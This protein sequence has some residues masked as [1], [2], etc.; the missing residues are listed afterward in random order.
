MSIHNRTIEWQHAIMM[1][2]LG[3][4]LL[5]PM[6]SMTSAAF[7]PMVAIMPELIWGVV[8]LITGVLRVIALYVNGSAPRGSPIARLFGAFVG[9]SIFSFMTVAFFNALP[10]ALFGVVY[11][12][13]M[14]MF[15]LRVIYNATKDLKHDFLYTRG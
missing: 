5:F 6:Q 12:F 13:V 10:T 15:E 14:G 7:A 8:F 4:G 2:L 1:I 9:V 11:S 3:I